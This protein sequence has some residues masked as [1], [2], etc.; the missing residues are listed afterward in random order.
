M[1][2]S[3]RDSVCGTWQYYRSYIIERIVCNPTS[4]STHHCASSIRR[5]V[6]GQARL[7]VVTVTKVWTI[8][9]QRVSAHMRDT[10]SYSIFLPRTTNKICEGFVLLELFLYARSLEIDRKF[11]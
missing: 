9:L 8:N 6:V 5:C 2:P 11:V 10:H 1:W 4:S 3:D 7:L